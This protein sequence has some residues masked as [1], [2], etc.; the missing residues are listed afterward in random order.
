MVDLQ[1]RF[2]MNSIV[3]SITLILRDSLRIRYGKP[4][5]YV[6][7]NPYYLTLH[8]EAHGAPPVFVLI[9]C[10]RRTTAKHRV[11]FLRPV[12]CN[13]LHSRWL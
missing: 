1:A 7:E 11:V 12:R 10:P 9:H 6:V 5:N 8:P 13:P 2:N 4:R 3:A